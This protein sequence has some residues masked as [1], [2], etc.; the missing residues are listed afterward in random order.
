MKKNPKIHLGSAN[1]ILKE[2]KKKSRTES[3]LPVTRENLR[4]TK[5]PVWYQIADYQVFD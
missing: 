4:L 1:I 3:N 5:K 2:S